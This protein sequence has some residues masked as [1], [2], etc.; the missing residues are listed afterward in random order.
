MTSKQAR[1]MYNKKTGG[2]KMSVEE[3]RMLKF[4]IAEENRQKDEQKR[5]ERKALACMGK[6]KKGWAC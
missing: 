1:K 3:E 5:N 4:H 6:G 2:K